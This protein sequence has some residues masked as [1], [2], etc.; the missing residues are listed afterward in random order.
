MDVFFH[1]PLFVEGSGDLSE[2]GIKARECLCFKGEEGR[3][4][5]GEEVG[6]E[7]GRRE[8]SGIKK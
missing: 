2:P 8:G 4:R 1:G 3:V 5:V 7:S 6:M